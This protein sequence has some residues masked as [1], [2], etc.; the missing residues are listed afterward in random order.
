MAVRIPT[1]E[2]HVQLDAGAQTIPRYPRIDE[3]GRAISQAGNSMI[4]VAAHWRQKQDQFDRMQMHQ[5]VTVLNQK[6]AQIIE[7]EAR[8]F[9]ATRD[10]PGTMHDRVIERVNDEIT[11]FRTQASPGL[12]KEYDVYGNTAMSTASSHAA[13]SENKISNHQI[14]TTVDKQVGEIIKG[15]LANPEAADTY[16]QQIKATLDQYDRL[17]NL[18]T[19]QKRIML[20]GYERALA[21]NV[22]TG[23]VQ[24]GRDTEARMFIESWS[25]ARDAEQPA[26]Q[27]AVGRPTGP[28]SDTGAGAGEANANRVAQIDRNPQVKDAIEKAAAATGMDPNALKVYASIESGGKPGAGSDTG[29]Y[30]G[31]FQLSKSEFGMNGG[32]D[33]YSPYDNAMAAAKMLSKR[34]DEFEQKTGQ[35]ATAT[36]LYMIH[37]QGLAGYLSHRSDPD[38]P[39]YQAMLNTAEGKQKGVGWAKQAIWGNIPNDLK[40]QFG[41][42]EN[43]KSSDLYNIYDSK[44]RGTRINLANQMPSGGTGEP[45]RTVTARV[46]GTTVSDAAPEKTGGFSYQETGTKPIAVSAAPTSTAAATGDTEPKSPAEAQA[47]GEVATQVAQTSPQAQPL[48]RWGQWATGAM[49]DVDAQV[50]KA[51]GIK[52][53]MTH[54]LNSVLQSDIASITASGKPVTLSKD[55]QDYFHTKDLTFDFVSNKLG[56]GAALTW[57]ENRELAT[58]AYGATADMAAMPAVAVEE[59]LRGLQPI[60]GSPD[61][62]NQKK[63]FDHAT[64]AWDAVRKEREID[65]AAA[66]DKMPDV[67]A[68]REKALKNPND[69]AA[70]Q[71]LITAR[72]K[73]QDYLQIPS[74]VQ[75]PITNGQARQFAVVVRDPM[76]TPTEAAEVLNDNMRRMLG[77]NPEWQRLATQK[78]LNVRGVTQAQRAAVADQLRAINEKEPEPTIKVSPP[79]A[80]R[81]TSKSTAASKD[82]YLSGD[83]ATGGTYDAYGVPLPQGWSPGAYPPDNYADNPSA[84]FVPGTTFIAPRHIDALRKDPSLAGMFDNGDPNTGFVGYGPGAAQWVLDQAKGGSAV[85]PVTPSAPVDSQMPAPDPTTPAPLPLTGIGG[86]G[87]EFMQDDSTAGGE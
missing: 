48:S 24:S 19:T 38:Q 45:P 44:V 57:Q 73:A 28:R 54:K 41:N 60:D 69:V 53:S 3:V 85:T 75:S 29:S 79:A 32:G 50:M 65:P 14:T 20:D 81:D 35:K 40:A 17:G 66:A 15:A 23:Y 4:Q 72:M 9:D 49:A 86:F 37:Q 46:D 56:T 52:T 84:T 77:A 70:I 62:Q 74:D 42:V 12:V 22:Y 58:R 27:D 5:N 33:I 82:G 21:K 39:A 26:G 25:R 64:K 78:I 34:A 55:L 63:V 13:V 87:D 76:R 59:R 2:R 67:A 36:D 71:E 11:K 18:T 16:H 1:Y 7:E 30:K 51:Q 43:V 68:A 6:I 83:M 10:R 80:Q 8:N 31:L 47:V 61:Y